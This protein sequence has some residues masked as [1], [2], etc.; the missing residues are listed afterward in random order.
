[1]NILKRLF[2]EKPTAIPFHQGFDLTGLPIITLHQKDRKLNFLL[3][4]GS[5]HNIIDAGMLDTITYKKIDDKGS[6]S[7][8]AGVS[9]EAGMCI[10][11][12]SYK[13]SNYMAGFLSCDMASAFG[14]IKET[15]GVNLHGLLGSDFFHRFHYVLDFAEL[16]AY[17]KNQ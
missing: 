4:T 10:I 9:K 14:H 13:K 1:M 3:D 11:P 2:K 6:I 5:T 7:G 15:S 16:I 17:S 12:F 8:L